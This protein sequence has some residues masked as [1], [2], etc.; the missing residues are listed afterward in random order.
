MFGKKTY[1]IAEYNLAISIANNTYKATEKVVYTTNIKKH[2]IE[3][4]KENCKNPV[5]YVFKNGKKIKDITLN[6]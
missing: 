1:K 3:Y 4:A 6:F 2:A 5:M